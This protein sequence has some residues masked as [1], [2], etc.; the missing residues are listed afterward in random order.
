MQFLIISKMV[1]A[2]HDP[3]RETWEVLAQISK[4]SWFL[5]TGKKAPK[6]L[7]KS[8]VTILQQV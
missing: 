5:E 8:K 7:D 2:K 4:E 6:H 3:K 1:R